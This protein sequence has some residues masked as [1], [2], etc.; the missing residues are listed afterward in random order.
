MRKKKKLSIILYAKY[1]R[2][3]GSEKNNQF[4]F[5]KFHNSEETHERINSDKRI[6]SPLSI[7]LINSLQDTP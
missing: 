4:L 7:F 2:N 3:H 6:I 5:L 1:F